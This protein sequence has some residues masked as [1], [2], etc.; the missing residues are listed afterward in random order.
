[1]GRGEHTGIDFAGTNL[2][3]VKLASPFS[4]VFSPGLNDNSSRFLKGC[5]GAGI[6]FGAYDIGYLNAG[7]LSAWDSNTNPYPMFTM[8]ST[9]NG[10]ATQDYNIKSV[11][12]GFVTT[13]DMESSVPL[14]KDGFG[15]E[16]YESISTTIPSA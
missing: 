10:W 6:G 1:M 11:F 12:I 3:G 14:S 8:N 2:K 15:N 5:G 13:I 9:L 7:G 16:G 4:M